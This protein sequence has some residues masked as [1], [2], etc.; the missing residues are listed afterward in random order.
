MNDRDEAELIRMLARAAEAAPEPAG[1][2]IGTIHRR[3]RQRTRR[4]VQSA[5]AV[6]GVIA[7]IG[8]G[9]AV[10]RGTFSNRGGEGQIVSKATSSTEGSP[11]F[12]PSPSGPPRRAVRPA[13]EVWPS[14]VFKIPAKAADGWKYRPVT[15]LSA[16]ELLLTAESSFE[17]AGRLEV[18]DTTAGKSTVLANMP[19]TDTKGYFVQGYEVGAEYIAW[20][21]ETP[22]NSDKW[23]D[24]WVVPRS[25]GT[26]KRVGEVTGDLS[27][28]TRIAVT[29]DSIVWSVTSGG[30]YRMPISGGAPERIE[31]TEGLHLLSWPLAVDFGEKEGGDAFKNQSRVVNLETRQVTEVNVPDGVENLR[32]GPVW[33]FGGWGDGALVQ[34]LD[35]SDRKILQGMSAGPEAKDVGGRFGSLGSYGDGERNADGYAPVTV[36]YDPISDVMAG[37]SKMDPSAGGGFGT[38]ISSSPS[39]ILY[40]DE[41]KKQVREC[42]TVDGR[43]LPPASSGEPVPTGEGTVCS[44]NEVGGGKEL[45]VVNLLAVPPTE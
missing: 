12:T 14:A 1:D 40:W 37:I 42:K 7:V 3:R 32:C 30:I 26:P 11:L 10:A 22:N 16:T 41:G 29:S 39:S 31:G 2:L 15:G 27:R 38:G 8:G 18:Y 21:G 35:G 34:R 19:V 24:F 45:T 23:A 17:K 36:V 43:I 9:T 33:C 13:A 25:G 44:T 20:W 6:A 4:R 28:V 5:L